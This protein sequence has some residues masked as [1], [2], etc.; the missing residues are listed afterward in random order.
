[1]ALGLADAF[2][3]HDA[4]GLAA[5]TPGDCGAQM[6]ARKTL[7]DYAGKMWEH[8]KNRGL[9]PGNRPEWN[10]VAGLRDLTGALMEQAMLAQ[11]DAG[12]EDS[13]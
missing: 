11:S 3:S 9:E 12:D 4:A 1:M 7:H 5:L 8:A 13:P 6:R 2:A 10:V